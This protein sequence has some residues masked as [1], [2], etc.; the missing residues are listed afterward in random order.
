MINSQ[1][2]EPI[3]VH[4]P[5]NQRTVRMAGED[6]KVMDLA[7][8]FTYLEYA[9]GMR[10]QT[11]NP[12]RQWVID[13]INNAG[14]TPGVSFIDT[15]VYFVFDPAGTPGNPGQDDQGRSITDDVGPL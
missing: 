10:F 11:H 8:G 2:G 12:L 4:I 3:I 13:M 14:P 5:F 1:D 15:N 9:D 6:R 7:A